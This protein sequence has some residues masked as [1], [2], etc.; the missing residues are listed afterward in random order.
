ML[1]YRLENQDGVG[2]FYGGPSGSTLDRVAGLMYRYSDEMSVPRGDLLP[3]HLL[4][5]Y[6]FVDVES[7]SFLPDAVFKQ[8]EVFGFSVVVFYVAN[9]YCHYVDQKQVLFRRDKAKVVERLQRRFGR[10]VK[11]K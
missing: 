11:E 1:V 9:D 8:L 3:H 5:V 10:W 2:P 4:E 7:F 6:A